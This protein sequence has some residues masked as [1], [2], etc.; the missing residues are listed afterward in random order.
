MAGFTGNFTYSFGPNRSNRLGQVSGCF[1]VPSSTFRSGER[2][3]RVTE[4]FNN[5]FDTDSI[6]FAENTF[7]SSGLKVDKTTLVD[8]VY[9]VGVSPKVVGSTTETRLIGREVRRDIVA[10]WIVD[11]LAQ[12]FYVDPIVY[13]YGLFLDNV[14]IFFKQKDDDDLPVRIQ[15]RP[16]IN[17]V[18]HTD[19]WYPESDVS[20]YPSQINI[21]DNPDVL[22]N[23]TKTNFKFTSPVFLK[24][25]LY[26]LVILTDSPIYQ[27]WVAE[28]GAITTKGENVSVNPY[29][30]TLYKS[31]NAMEY[32]PIINEDLMFTMNR[33]VFKPGT[34]SFILQTLPQNRIYNI[35]RFRVIQ[36]SLSNL[37][38]SPIKLDYSFISKTIGGVKEL[39]YRQI[40]PQI[41]YSM[42]SDSK[43]LVGGRRKILKDQG[44]FTLKIDM[45]T[46]NDAI[47]P[48]VSLESVYLNAWENFVDNAEISSDEFNIIEPGTGYSN[49]N[50]ITV[51]SSTGSGAQIFLNVDANG[52]VVSIN[53]QSSGTNYIDD[54]TINVNSNT[55]TG[56]EIVLNSEY[57][58]SGGPC[59]ARY[60]TKPISL[61]DGFDAGDLRVFLGANKPG[62]SEIEVF[63]KILSQNDPSTFKERRYQKMECVNPT[64]TPS[65][66]ESDYREY[67]YR[68][69]LITNSVSY[70]SDSG[71][72]YDTFKTFAIKIVMLSNDKS[73]V[74]KVKDL[75]IIALP[76]D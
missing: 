65:S 74:P 62:N 8:T 72:T 24:P 1:Y 75:R 10:S 46:T 2:R 68:P 30:G 5:T 6:S 70:T 33:C 12:T 47:S 34:A 17:G 57:D 60:I 9:N 7:V 35:D 52:N 36:T 27:V 71:V 32:V 45:A 64:T 37:S 56:A 59:N 3:F 69:S 11:P 22:I 61:A 42:G 40:S 76:G 55:G 66:T 58:S 41:I 20:K 49:S 73:V 43:Y 38:D 29:I 48:V 18:P 23:S 53:V 21:S 39:E 54:F 31:Q 28:K 50:T 13:P 25:G 67:E 44:D 51:N 19:F 15:I 14:D 63:Y 26:A 16:T 4:S